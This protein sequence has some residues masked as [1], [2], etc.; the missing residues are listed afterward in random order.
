MLCL[1]LT[2]NAP[3]DGFEHVI[4]MKAEGEDGSAATNTFIKY[5]GLLS[6]STYPHRIAYIH[7]TCTF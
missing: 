4:A 2:C 5:C 7:F 3:P 1:H 6:C